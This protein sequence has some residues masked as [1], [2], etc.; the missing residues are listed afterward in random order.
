MK[1]VMATAP[2]KAVLSGEY[3][4]LHGAPAICMAVDRRAIARVSN[5]ETAWNSVTAPGYSTS[6]GRFVCHGS[7]LEWLQGQDDFGLVDAAFEVLDRSGNDCVSVELDTR[8]F[9][10]EASGTKIG[11]GSSAALTVALSAALIQS[12]DV[13]DDAL[14]IHRRFQSGAGSGVDIATAVRGG[15]LEYRMKCAEV[16]PLVWPQGLAYRL[17]WTG[18]PA[19]TKSKLNRFEGAGHRNSRDA[20]VNAATRMATAW[21]SASAVLGVFPDYVDTLRKFSEDYDLGIFDASHDK[22][23]AESRSAG[24]IYKPCGA[25]GGDVGILM[26]TTYEKL[27]EFLAG[28][29]VAGCRVLE[30]K[31]DTQGVAWGQR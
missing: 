17:V 16:S 3:A 23:V 5:V 4:V 8:A 10:D 26:G 6:E 20:L 31:L 9:F 22:L 19:D 7:K 28:F 21:P 29:P 27:D 30:S 2:G 18:V 11:L 13:I 25:G 24:L 15:L 14:E 1:R 12:H